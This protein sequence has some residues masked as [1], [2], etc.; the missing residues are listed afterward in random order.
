MI[1]DTARR[2][3]LNIY[4]TTP[5]ARHV[6]GVDFGNA[7]YDPVLDA[8]YID[9][10]FIDHGVYLSLCRGSEIG[11][12]GCR[13]RYPSLDV[14]FA[15]V[16]L[17]ELGH[18]QLHGVG[19]GWLAH[20]KH[21]GEVRAREHEADLYALKALK[22]NYKTGTAVVSDD[23]QADTLREALGL[24]ELAQTA[25]D[26]AQAMWSDLVA[27]LFMSSVLNSFL[28]GPYSP[29][30]TDLAHPSFL[31]RSSGLVDAALKDKSL[32]PMVREHFEFFKDMLLKQSTA[33]QAL[34]AEL[35]SAE[36]IVDSGFA[37]DSVSFLTDQ[38]RRLA[39]LPL[40]SLGR[41]NGS[42]I[43]AV[44]Q[45]ELRPGHTPDA[46]QEVTWPSGWAHGRSKVYWPMS[47]GALLVVEADGSR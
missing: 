14:L 7:A 5:T 1:N 18:R 28:G 26:N 16:L 11:M 20:D 15:F 45:P 24:R 29:F 41:E 12:L 44:L 32:H 19:S 21:H 36:P 31:V 42:K 2:G 40:K 46:S 3:A 33:S 8:I 13:E 47:D 34:A 38:G 22:D 30:Y 9:Q 6:T 39:E 37:G 17:H 43:A 4:I 27:A 10:S 35:I 25:E 23:E